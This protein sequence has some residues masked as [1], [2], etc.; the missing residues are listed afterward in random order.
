[1]DVDNRRRWPSMT[2][3]FDV[4]GYHIRMSLYAISDSMERRF[5]TFAGI[6]YKDVLIRRQWEQMWES[7]RSEN[8]ENGQISRMRRR[9]KNGC[10]NGRPISDLPHNAGDA[11]LRHIEL[12]SMT[13]K[14]NWLLPVR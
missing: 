10:L 6:P 9:S 2:D 1:M 14:T 12:G 11:P 8:F 4:L 13:C 5:A 7:E 3:L